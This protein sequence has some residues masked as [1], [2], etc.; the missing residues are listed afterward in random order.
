MP[1]KLPIISTLTVLAISTLATTVPTFAEPN[2]TY[3]VSDLAP[4]HAQYANDMAECGAYNRYDSN[5][6]D[7]YNRITNEY[8]TRYGGKFESM[9]QLDYNGRMVI[10]G[11]NPAAG[12]VRLYIDET[13]AYRDNAF[14]FQNLVAFW[15]DDTANPSPNWDDDAAWAIVDT[16]LAGEETPQ[17]VHI[18]YKGVKD[19]EGWITPNTEYRTTYTPSGDFTKDNFLAKFFYILGYDTAGNKHLERN[20]YS[21]CLEG[22]TESNECRLQYTYNGLYASKNYIKTGPTTEDAMLIELKTAI[23]EAEEAEAAAR[24]AEAA[25]REATEAANAAIVRAEEAE[26]AARE[27]EN[28]A[29]EAATNAREAEAIAR[30]AEAN[31]DAVA[32][33]AERIAREASEA[34]KESARIA[35][36]ANEVAEAANQKAAQISEASA[37]KINELSEKIADLNARIAKISSDIKVTEKV[38]ERVVEKPV[39]IVTTNTIETKS[40]SAKSTDEPKLA[41]LP[42]EENIASTN[43]EYVEVPDAGKEAEFPWWIIAFVFSGIALIL[44]WCVP[45][46]KK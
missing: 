4:L 43:D 25:A 36:E 8:R 21:G 2:E 6:M 1:K 46:R 3:S 11:L 29:N 9:Y 7:C 22:F 17:G 41:A 24:E 15:A 35:A 28:V 32:I 33:K 10:T 42:T 19:E 16:I 45:A 14:T 5:F 31:A 18:L 27:A 20:E 40:D 12:T 44:W 38:T 39:K 37:Q 34:A 26:A 13:K 23:K 30:A